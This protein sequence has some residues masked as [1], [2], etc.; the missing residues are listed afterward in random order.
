MRIDDIDIFM[1]YNIIICYVSIGRDT[2]SDRPIQ[3]YEK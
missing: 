1:L 3:S 2:G